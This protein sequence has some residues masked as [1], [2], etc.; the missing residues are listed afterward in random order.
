MK[1]IS[2]SRAAALRAG[3]FCLIYVGGVGFMCW[4]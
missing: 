2:E 4:V 1:K 3:A